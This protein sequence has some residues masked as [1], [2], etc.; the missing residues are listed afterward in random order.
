MIDCW[1]SLDDRMELPVLSSP[2][3]SA[4]PACFLPRPRPLFWPGAFASVGPFFRAQSAAAPRVSGAAVSVPAGDPHCQRAA[5][6]HVVRATS[7]FN[8]RRRFFP[9]AGAGGE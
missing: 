7:R 8:D 2:P 4:V 1:P 5:I 9:A 3:G 6:A